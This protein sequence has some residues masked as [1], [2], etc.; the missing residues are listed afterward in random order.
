MQVPTESEDSARI[1]TAAKHYVG[2]QDIYSN[3]SSM[4]SGS[5][6]IADQTQVSVLPNDRSIT[7]RG[8]PRFVGAVFQP[9]RVSKIERHASKRYL[10]KVHIYT[11]FTCILVNMTR[12]SLIKIHVFGCCVFFRTYGWLVSPMNTFVTKKWKSL[13]IYARL[14][15]R[16]CSVFQEP[17]PCCKTVH[18]LR[19]RRGLKRDFGHTQ[20]QSL[21]VYKVKGN[22]G[23]LPPRVRLDHQR[24]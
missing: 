14:L 24:R 13:R 3:I 12:T 9:S 20:A 21:T 6:R 5:F 10:Y 15:C 16:S 17:S 22:F 7:W 8:F 18:R 19:Q 23:L 1:A 4:K 11:R 2:E